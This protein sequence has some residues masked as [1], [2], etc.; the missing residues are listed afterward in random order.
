MVV[1]I[2]KITGNL[3]HHIS[4][5]GGDHKTAVQRGE[6]GFYNR[7]MFFLNKFTCPS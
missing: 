7:K 5:E 3:L 6:T 2:A 4:V 1:L